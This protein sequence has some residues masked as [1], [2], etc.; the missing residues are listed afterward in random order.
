MCV[1]HAVAPWQSDQ[2]LL[3]T[4]LPQPVVTRQAV[5]SFRRAFDHELHLYN[6]MLCLGLHGL[7]VPRCSAGSPVLSVSLL[8]ERVVYLQ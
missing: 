3:R 8:Y 2:S 1:L 4:P 5:C 6:S 7:T